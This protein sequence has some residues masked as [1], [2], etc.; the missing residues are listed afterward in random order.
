MAKS[1]N[2]MVIIQFSIV[3]IGL[4]C[5]NFIVWSLGKNLDALQSRQDALANRVTD[6]ERGARK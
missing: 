1:M 5:L 3:V 2:A 4:T 6:L